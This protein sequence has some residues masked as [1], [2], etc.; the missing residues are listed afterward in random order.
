MTERRQWQGTEAARRI[1]QERY[2]AGPD[3]TPEQMFWRVA[4]EVAKAEENYPPGRV[5]RY[6]RREHWAA[7]FYDL[8]VSNRFL[9]NSPTL[10]NAGRGTHLQLSACYV[11][12]IEDSVASIYGTMANAARIHQSGGGTGF[13]FS[14]LRQ[15]GALVKTAGGVASGPVTFLRAYDG[16]TEAIKQGGRR[17]GANLADLRVDHPDVMEFIDCKRGGGI[18]NFNISVAITDLFMEALA[19]DMHYSLVAP[20]TGEIVSLIL[21]R[22]VFD[23]ICE[24]AWQTGDPGL[25]FIDRVNASSANPVPALETIE[26]SNPCGET[27][28]G[29]FDVCNLGSI[30]LGAFWAN[31]DIEWMALEE[32]ARLG[33]RFLDDVIDVNP[34]P[35]PEIDR[36]AKANRRVGL[37]VMGWAD[38]LTKA[39]IPYDSDAALDLADKVMHFIKRKGHEESECLAATRGP[40]PRWAQSIYADGTPKRNG[41]VTTIAPTGTIAILAGCSSGIEPHFALA[42]QHRVKQGGGERVL[43]FFNAELERAARAE[44][45]WTDGFAASIANSGRLAGYPL[46]E[47]IPQWMR[48]VFKTAHEIAPEWHVRH[49]AAF[50]KHTDNAV[51]KTVNLPRDATVEDV[52]KA[53]LLSWELGCLGITVFRDGCKDTQVLHA[54]TGKEKVVT[55]THGV[56]LPTADDAL[57]SSGAALQLIEQRQREAAQKKPRPAV[58]HGATHRVETPLGTAY[59]TVNTNGEG[60]PFEVFANVGKAG[61]DTFAVSEAIGRLCS[62]ALRMPS[63]VLPRERV[64]EIVDQ[65]SGIGGSRHLGFGKDRVRSLPDAIAKVLTEYAAPL[66]TI[67]ANAEAVGGTLWKQYSVGGLCPRCG[68]LALV[69]EEGCVKCY[70][71]FFAEC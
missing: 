21:A 57:D 36:V 62:Y 65:L 52:K 66:E 63:A 2:L 9:P 15:K 18:T 30:N 34:Y 45:V 50:Q 47:R 33:V 35:L 27:Y 38:L 25:A 28:L 7:Q 68:E 24:A 5:E 22:D 19:S 51:S 6:E 11:L 53:Y 59:V 71:C 12:P 64:R 61:S 56:K 13:A 60:Q 10:M 46:S 20:H 26:A 42:Y 67:F 4:W 55:D 40:F 69:H 17:R 31:G 32:T 37:G 16:A 48:D 3:E 1:L 54:G 39:R 8:M 70:S 49:Q 14:R 58:V 44:G 41:T 23:R 43:D 29:P